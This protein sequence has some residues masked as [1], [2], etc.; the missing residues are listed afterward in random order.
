MK[1]L[2]IANPIAVT[3]SAFGLAGSAVGLVETLA[4]GTT[5]VVLSGLHRI[6]KPAEQG[7]GTHQPESA[8]APDVTD[9]TSAAQAD[10]PVTISE[11]PTVVLAEPHAPAEPPIDVVGQAIAAEAARGDRQS[12]EGAG[13]AHEPRGA[14]RDEEH[15]DAPLQRAEA[16][17]IAEEVTAALEG[18]VEPDEHLTEPLLDPADAKALAAE[19]ETLARAAD[20]HKG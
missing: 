15:G 13:L 19:M 10:A 17:G 2:K 6:A 3:K 20:P 12:P 16:E 7:T 9:P 4:G 14:S 8:A 11:G 5:R 18:D 1:L